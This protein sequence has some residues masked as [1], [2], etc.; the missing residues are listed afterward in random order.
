MA[1]FTDVTATEYR[2]KPANLSYRA[3]AVYSRVVSFVIPALA[4]VATGDLTGVKLPPGTLLLGGTVELSAA[5]ESSQTLGFKTETSN[6]VFVPQVAYGVSSAIVPTITALAVP[7]S[8]T[9]D[10]QVQC[11]MAGAT[12]G[13]ADVTVKLTMILCNAGEATQQVDSFDT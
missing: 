9:A 13:S 11:V 7:N 4:T 6:I 1:A 8:A 12:A 2:N 3:N 5:L 10:D